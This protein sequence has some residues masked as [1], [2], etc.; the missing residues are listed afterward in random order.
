MFDRE[1][2]REERRKRRDVWGTS[3]VRE[4][5]CERRDAWGTSLAREEMRGGWVKQTRGGWT[6]PAPENQGIHNI[7]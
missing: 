5:T 7:V 1:C 2:V 3:L 4:E 6:E